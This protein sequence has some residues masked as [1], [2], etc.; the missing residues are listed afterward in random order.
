MGPVMIFQVLIVVSTNVIRNHLSIL[1]LIFPIYSNFYLLWPYTFLNDN[2]LHFAVLRSISILYFYI[3]C[4][5]TLEILVFWEWFF[6]GAQMLKNIFMMAQLGYGIGNS[7]FAVHHYLQFFLAQLRFMAVS[8]L[9]HQQQHRVFYSRP[10]WK[11][12]ICG[13]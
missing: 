1:R 7:F 3:S 2:F 9:H 6:P 13:R 8:E 4:F 5:K 12:S 11:V 10:F